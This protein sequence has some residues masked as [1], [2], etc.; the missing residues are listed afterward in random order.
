MNKI[1]KKNKNQEETLSRHA[2]Q[3]PS[4]TRSEESSAHRSQNTT[5]NEEENTFAKI[6][7]LIPQRPQTDGSKKKTQTIMTQLKRK[8]E[9][10]LGRNES[11]KE[12]KIDEK[13]MK[14]RH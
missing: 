3:Q 13:R 10:K 7:S 6:R 8:K 1:C 14:E 9:E 2:E 12:R 5:T 11:G 4:I